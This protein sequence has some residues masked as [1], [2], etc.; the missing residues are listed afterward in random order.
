MLRVGL[1]RVV[2]GGEGEARDGQ[3]VC[4]SHNGVEGKEVVPTKF[5]LTE[6]LL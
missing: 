4:L 3:L 5:P 6:E 1:V 2:D